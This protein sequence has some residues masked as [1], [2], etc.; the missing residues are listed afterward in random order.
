MSALVEK[1][2]RAREQRVTVGR[3]VFVIRRPTDVEMLRLGQSRAPEAVLA[4]VVG[5]EGVTEGDIIN[6]G[7]PHPLP[8]DADVC[9]EWLQDRMDLF[10]PV[11]EAIFK[12]FAD[13]RAAQD[14]A[15][16]N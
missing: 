7:D 16:G 15:A 5:W 3:H 4:H 8:F 1:I 6:G 14:A 11:T 12:A 2:R 9:T 10:G 13:H